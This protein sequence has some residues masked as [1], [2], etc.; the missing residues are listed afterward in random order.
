ML[1]DRW[2]ARGRRAPRVPDRPGRGRHPAAVAEIR[3]RLARR[4]PFDAG[5]FQACTLLGAPSVLAKVTSAAVL[6][7]EAYTVDVEVEVALG[8]PAYNVVGLP[9]G[10]VK[11]G[12]VRV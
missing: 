1:D 5:D 6:G 7:I 2:R 11:E 3:P 10:A 9:A 8:L 4:S 12:G